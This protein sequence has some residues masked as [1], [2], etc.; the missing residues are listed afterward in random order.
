MEIY[1]I[2]NLLNGKKYVGQT[3]LSHQRRFKRHCNSAGRDKNVFA[4][5]R[6]IAKYGKEN[7][8]VE[9]LQ[10]C[11]AQDELNDA[12]IAWIAKLSTIS[13]GGYN[14]HHGGGS[15]GKH[16]EES[17]RK[18]SLIRKGWNPS[19]ETRKRISLAQTGKKASAEAKMRNSLAQL[20][21][22]V[23]SEAAMKISNSLKGHEISDEVRQKI[24]SKLKGRVIDEDVRKRMSEAQIGLKR[25]PFSDE[26]R[27]RM[28]AAGKARC[29]REK[30]KKLE[31][32]HGEV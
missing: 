16:S 1:V 14:L 25:K 6:A 23:S 19:A 15:K 31:A 8:S 7:F 17:K 28:S 3:T 10:R 5:H 11:E 12:E 24:S 30:A 26:A 21:H 32:Q 27:A 4:I 20:G 13:P 2:T 9:L 22:A 18:M 29:A